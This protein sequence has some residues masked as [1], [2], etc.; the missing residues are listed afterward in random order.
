MS[1][2]RTWCLDFISTYQLYWSVPGDRLEISKLPARAF[3]NPRQHAETA[4]LFSDYNTNGY[5]LSTEIDARFST[6]AAERYAAHPFRAHVLLPIGRVADMWLRPR[7][8]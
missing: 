6:L 3:D 1:W 4:A 7:V 5:S 8:E 2:V